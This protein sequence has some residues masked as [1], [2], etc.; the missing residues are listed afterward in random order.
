[1]VND[2]TIFLR[3]FKTMNNALEQLRDLNGDELQHWLNGMNDDEFEEWLT[4]AG[5]LHSFQVCDNCGGRMKFEKR[6]W[7]CYKR[8]C[9]EGHKK[10][11]KGLRA[12]T[13]FE[14][15]EL[16]PKQVF[17]LSYL[18]LQGRLTVDDTAYETKI[19]HKTIVHWWEK[20]RAICRGI[21]W[22]V[23]KN[24]NV[25][26]LITVGILSWSVVIM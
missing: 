6:T 23:L 11:Q 24:V 16:S 26:K 15:A 14:H 19:S 3:A 20:F 7:I 22:K 4:S 8:A 1:M 10:P 25:F 13:F 9:R 18:W 17:K 2:I 21:F 12:K 5:L